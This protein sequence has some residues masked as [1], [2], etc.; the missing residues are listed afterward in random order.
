MGRKHVGGNLKA[1]CCVHEVC[2]S[3]FCS[4]PDFNGLRA[5]R[6]TNAGEL[7]QGTVAEQHIV[8]SCPQVVRPYYG[9]DL[10]VVESVGIGLAILA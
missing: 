3:N 8:Q 2:E 5:R 1:A 6:A 10:R 9:P 4:V 7:R